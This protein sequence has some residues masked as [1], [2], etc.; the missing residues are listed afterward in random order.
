MNWIK[1]EDE[2]PPYS[3]AKEEQCIIVS[4]EDNDVAI[5]QLYIHDDGVSKQMGWF[6]D[7][8]DWRRERDAS[9]FKYWL[10]IPKTPNE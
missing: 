1:F 4:T 8:S 6:V 3:M 10:P 7:S 2:K 9:D 5:A